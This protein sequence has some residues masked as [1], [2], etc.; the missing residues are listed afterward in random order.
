MEQM[1]HRMHAAIATSEEL[2]RRLAVLNR[3]YEGTIRQLHTQLV[4]AKT[5][6][7]QVEFD[8]TRQ[9]SIMDRERREALEKV[10]SV[11]RGKKKDR[12]RVVKVVV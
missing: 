6:R 3:Y 8:L 12:K 5:D 7:D 11:A 10:A 1:G 4:E 2:R 9:I